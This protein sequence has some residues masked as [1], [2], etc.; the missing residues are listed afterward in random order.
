[1]IELGAEALGVLVV[2]LGVPSFSGCLTFLSGVVF[3][4]NLG[5]DV[6]VGLLGALVTVGDLAGLDTLLD[7]GAASGFGAAFVATLLLAFGICSAVAFSLSWSSLVLLTSSALVSCSTSLLEVG[8]FSPDP[9]TPSPLD[10]PD[11]ADGACVF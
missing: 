8:V 5:V 10:P 6:S 11:T 2:F 9:F 7:D 1:L 4:V 3:A